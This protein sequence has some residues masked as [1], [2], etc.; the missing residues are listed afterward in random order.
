MFERIKKAF[1]RSAPAGAAQRAHV[2]DHHQQTSEWAH[3]HGLAFEGSAQSASFTVSGDALGKPWRLQRA[4][5]SRPFIHGDELRA[6]AELGLGTD[7]AVLVINRPLKEALERQAYASFTDSLQTTADAG[8][9]EELRWLSMFDELGWPGAPDAFWTRYAVVGDNLAHAQAWLD[10]AMCG[11]LLGW[12]QDGPDAQ[13]PFTMMLVRGKAYL[14]MEYA[15]ADLPTLA[16]T[17]NI[18]VT[19]C[20][21][22]LAGLGPPGA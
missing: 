13:T 5:P 4:R 8:T 1:G 16:Y 20:E 17:T 12:P 10:D 22:A 2:P 6:R 9:H 11:L 21:T 7:V 18:F 14:R 15:P 3:R 19:A